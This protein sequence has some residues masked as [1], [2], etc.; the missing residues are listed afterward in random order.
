M[1]RAVNPVFSLNPALFFRSVS[2]M[3]ILYQFR[4]LAKDL[5]DTLVFAVILF[6]GFLVPVFLAGFGR[7]VSRKPAVFSAV[8]VM[9]L[10]PWTVRFFIGAP[11]IFFPGVALVPDALLLNLDRNIFS[12]LLPYYWAAF[13]TYFSCRSRTFLRADIIAGAFVLLAVFSAGS[14]ADIALYRWPVVMIAVFAPAALMQALALMLS[15]PPALNLRRKEAVSGGAVFLFLVLLGSLFFLEPSQEKA[16]DKGGGLLEPRLFSFDFSRILRLDSEIS[17]NDDLVLIVKKDPQDDHVLLRRYVLSGYGGKQGFYRLPEI[18][19]ASH[20]ARLPDRRTRFAAGDETGRRAPDGQFPQNFTRIT[21]QEYYLVNFD[22]SAFVAMNRPEEV[23][24]FENRDASSFNSAYAVRSVT[25]GAGFFELFGAASWPPRAE[26][27]GLSSGEYRLYTDYGGEERIRA[28]AEE[29]TEGIDGYGEKIQAVYNRLKFGEYRYSLKPGAAPDGDQLAWF[30]LESK[31]GYCSYYA[32]AMTLMLR[33]LGIP[34]RVAAGFVIDPQANTFGY[35]PVRANMAH[36]WVEVPF[37]GQGWIEYD[38]TTVEFAAGEEFR[39]SA[40]DRE[41]FERLMKEILDHHSRW[42]PKEDKTD[43]GEEFPGSRAE[44]AAVFARRYWFPFS[45]LVLAAVFLFLRCGFFI[46]SCFGP[47]GKRA[48]RLWKHVKRRLALA[49]LRK[50]PLLAEAEWIAELEKSA[51]AGSGIGALYESV[52]AARFAPDFSGADFALMKKRYRSFSAAHRNAV[53]PGRRLAGWV[54]PPLALLLRKN[55]GWANGRRAGLPV[56]IAAFILSGFL[57]DAQDRTGSETADFLF[58]EARRAGS[59]ENWERA[60]ELFSRGKVR[61]PGESRFPLALG[62]LYYDRGLYRL[63]W[64]EYR[65]AE[66]VLNEDPDLFLKL[67]KTAAALNRDEVSV[68]YLERLLA[69]SPENREAIGNLGWM[70]YKVHRLAD[71]RRLLLDAMDRFGADADY[72]MTLGTLYLETLDYDEGK[73]W[74][75]AA[76]SGGEERGDRT[77]TAVAHY[78]LS[79]LESRFH[80]YRSAWERAGLSLQSLSRSS[81]YLVRGEMSLR[82]LDFA[83]ALQDYRAAYE[84]DSSPLSKI[85]LARVYLFTGRLKEAML[86]AEDCLGSEN[87]SWMANFGIDPVRY[88]RDLHEVLMKT[89]AG[90]YRTECLTPW[91]GT[92]EKIQS[93]FRRSGLRFRE[94]V[95]RLLYRK[96]SLAAADNYRAAGGGMNLNA[97]IQYCGAFE[98]YPARALYYLREAAAIETALIPETGPSYDLEEGIF[99][100]RADLVA[101]AIDGLD[102]WWERDMAVYGYSMLARLA[103]GRSGAAVRRDAAERLFALNRGALRREGIVLRAEVRVEGADGEGF[104][105]ARAAELV[106]IL[107]KAGIDSVNHN[108]NMINEKNSPV[109]RFTLTIRI[110]GGEGPDALC[111][112]YDRSRG[113]SVLRRV[114]PLASLSRADLYAFVRALSDAVFTAE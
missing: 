47:P 21:S 36:A 38:P 113:T 69:V 104:E 94:T 67:S 33:S 8:L 49:G 56:I 103:R 35:Y 46:A 6:T 19:E 68:S 20:P 16:V 92:G 77:F 100:K 64:D 45:A 83:R 71:G 74:Y 105:E 25:F 51:D 29:I 101:Q 4:L 1:N 32:F 26:Q 82:R 3:I 95:H 73:R 91:G 58:D 7:N 98:D 99:M 10:V 22:A 12:A 96:Y 114:I 57:S 87:F 79:L 39:F 81:G 88:R 85:N 93:L 27:L 52:S 44:N 112:V 54:L 55:G 34:A 13:T 40:G 28:F 107:R 42:K 53:N 108:Q 65:G 41:F 48:V 90:L 106:R 75:L 11:R 80:N 23:I 62:D 89:C 14:T 60:I 78:N 76:V 61:Y 70:Y 24:P 18:D 2:L 86:Y 111:E 17:M 50:S 63:A 102:P 5:S 59:A 110:R 30:L 43:G 9:A 37:P 109:P 72:A 15:M 66:S 97:L 84:L 31:K